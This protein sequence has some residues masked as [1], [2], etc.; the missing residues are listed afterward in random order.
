MCRNLWLLCHTAESG[1]F[2]LRMRQRYGRQWSAIVKRPR[3]VS[4]KKL[5]HEE[6]R[7]H[8]LFLITTVILSR[9]LRRGFSLLP[10]LPFAFAVPLTTGSSQDLLFNRP[11]DRQ[12]VGCE[13]QLLHLTLG[14]VLHLSVPRFPH[15]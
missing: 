6:L 8:P 7:Q 1:F 13:D 2:A 14:R 3:E 12:S 5:A 11:L 4:R 9:L 10:S 15:L